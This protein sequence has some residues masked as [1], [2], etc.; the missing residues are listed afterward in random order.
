[1]KVVSK[2]PDGSVV[3]ELSAYELGTIALAG[4]EFVSGAFAPTDEE[5]ESLKQTLNLD[6]EEVAKIFESLP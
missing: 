4:N 5:W 6:R 1:M 3:M 2:E